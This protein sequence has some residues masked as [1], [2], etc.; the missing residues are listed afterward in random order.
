MN[1]TYSSRIILANKM[2]KKAKKVTS[3]IV[4]VFSDCHAY[5]MLT[6]Y[7]S[8]IRSVGEYCCLLLHPSSLLNKSFLKNTQ[9]SFTKIISVME[10]YDYWERLD[11]FTSL[12][13]SSTYSYMQYIFIYMWVITTPLNSNYLFMT[14]TGNMGLRNLMLK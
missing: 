4:S 11:N 12:H 3:W 10:C 2:N 1:S 6:L 13:C 8:L 9:C 14:Q 5:I 7:K